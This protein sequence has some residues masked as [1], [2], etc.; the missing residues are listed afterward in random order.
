[1]EASFSK[2]ELDFETQNWILA[3]TAFEQRHKDNDMRREFLGTQ[4]TGLSVQ[5]SC[6]ASQRE[7][8]SK[9][10]KG[11][12]NVLSKIDSLMKVGDIAIKSAPESVGLV[13]MGIRLCMSSFRD[14][15]ATFTRFSGACADIIGIMISCRVYGRMYGNRSGP[16]DFRE[17]HNKVVAFIPEIYANVLDFSYAVKKHMGKHTAGKQNTGL[18]ASFANETIS[19]NC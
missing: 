11:L 13:W 19:T 3:R 2:V 16:D 9:Y 1:M 6:L 5:E 4:T 7:A 18:I 12:G 14:D 8:G 10:A 15:F 17:I